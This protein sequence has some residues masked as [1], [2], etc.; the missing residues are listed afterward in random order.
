MNKDLLEESTLKK[1]KST[2][3]LDSGNSSSK[4]VPKRV[5]LESKKSALDQAIEK[6]KKHIFKD[7]ILC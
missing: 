5:K 4:S 7:V 2:N 6:K 1:K 3:R